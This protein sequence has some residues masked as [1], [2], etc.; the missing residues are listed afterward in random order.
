MPTQLSLEGALRKS[1][2]KKKR[3]QGQVRHWQ[4]INRKAEDHLKGR[5]DAINQDELGKVEL[6]NDKKSE[7][8]EKAV[9][10]QR[11]LRGR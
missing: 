5:L 4:S 7:Q 10:G 6:S 8:Q 3:S 2:V 1:Q 11:E 9:R